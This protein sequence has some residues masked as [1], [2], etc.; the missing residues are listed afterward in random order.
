MQRV[1]DECLGQMLA[2]R[3]V[4]IKSAGISQ[5]FSSG[6]ATMGKNLAWFAPALALGGGIELV[7]NVME[8]RRTAELE[9]QADSHFKAL[10]RTSEIAKGDTEMAR[11]AFETLKAVAPS[12][13]ARPL[14]AKTFIDYTVSQGRM[15]PETIQ[16]LAEAENSVRG[17]GAAQGK[18]GFME[19]MKGMMNLQTPKNQEHINR[20][21]SLKK[22]SR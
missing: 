8:S 5:V 20:L 12:L 10:M 4:M 13:A 9:H 14:V 18:G 16:Q 7:R 21:S 15:A 11:E 19:N 22:P 1:S 6:A 3:Y 2:E 17:I